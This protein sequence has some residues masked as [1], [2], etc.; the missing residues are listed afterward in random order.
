MMMVP[1]ARAVRGGTTYLVAGGVV[2]G[3]ASGGARAM[4]EE[5]RRGMV[6]VRERGITASRA[7]LFAGGMEMF[8]W[9][10]CRERETVL[11][12]AAAVASRCLRSK[13]QAGSE[14]GTRRTGASRIGISCRLSPLC[15][16]FR[17][18]LTLAL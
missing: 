12:A 3:G 7:C 1:G 16:D 11:K 6:Q 8:R 9:C 4:K 14:F 5:S 17:R 10:R 2:G 18:L 13:P 15:L